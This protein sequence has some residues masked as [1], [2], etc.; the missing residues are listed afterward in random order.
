M[1]SSGPQT[2][3]KIITY[4]FKHNDISCVIENAKGSEV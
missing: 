2:M 3:K 1:E 4:S